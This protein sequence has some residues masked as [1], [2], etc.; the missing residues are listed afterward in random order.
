MHTQLQTKLSLKI[1]TVVAMLSLLLPT[2]MTTDVAYA[3]G[4]NKNRERFYGIIQSKP[5]GLQGTWV[6]GGRTVTTVRGTEFDQL[7]GPLVVGACAKVDI[8]NGRVHE[9]DSEPM[10]NCR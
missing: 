1:I 3:K 2:L 9:I 10:R 6:I 5:A 7:Q 8:R 4:G